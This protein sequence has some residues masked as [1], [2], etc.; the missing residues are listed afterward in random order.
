MEMVFIPY[1]ER[2]GRVNWPGGARLALATYI[3]VEEW[4]HEN[5]V[6]YK[7]TPA[8]APPLFPGLKKA[9]LG[10]TT[11]KD[12]SWRVG[13]YRLMELL[14][15]LN[16]K[17]TLL[18][19]GLAAELH[20]QVLKMLVDQGHEVVGHAYDQARYMLHL[21]RSGQKE[22]IE[23]TVFFIKEATGVRLRGWGSP[24]TRQTEE[25]IELLAEAGFSYHMGFHDDEIPYFLK[26]GG[27]TLVEIPYRV[28]VTNGELVDIAIYQADKVGQEALEY[29]KFYF[30]ARY[31]ES[32]RT[33]Q[34]VSLGFHPFVSG[35]PERAKVLKQFL[36]YVKGFPDVWIATFG[37][38]ADWWK[39]T[40]ET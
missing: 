18:T 28:G 31:E 1:L 6:K 38:V 36:R 13:I 40:Y 14:S 24:G 26:V 12:Y 37:E 27:K 22:D 10:I 39:Q 4:G 32:A 30:D 17:T 25:T 11:V 15:E 5:I 2:K 19:N 16:L 9:D 35:R 34:F 33:P 8:M 7:G 3:G 21:D 29:M 23:K 20:P